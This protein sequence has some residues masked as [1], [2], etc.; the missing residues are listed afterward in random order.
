MYMRGV[1]DVP[2]EHDAVGG[3]RSDAAVRE[4]GGQDVRAVP[5]GAHELLVHADRRRGVIE[6]GVPADVL[7]GPGVRDAVRVV[8]GCRRGSRSPAMVWLK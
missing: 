1:L 7:P 2:L 5:G 8:V 3:G 6:A 4:G